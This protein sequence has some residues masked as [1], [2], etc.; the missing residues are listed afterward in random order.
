MAKKQSVID[1]ERGIDTNQVAAVLRTK[2]QNRTKFWSPK[3]G[4]VYR[5]KNADENILLEY[6]VSEDTIKEIEVN[7]D[8]LIPFLFE[9]QNA[10]DWSQAFE[11]RHATLDDPIYTGW[12]EAE[13]FSVT[14]YRLKKSR[15]GNLYSE[16]KDQYYELVAATRPYQWVEYTFA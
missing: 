13:P 11:P 2:A 16:G 14:M 1:A 3:P 12:I 8:F 10:T 6:N 9:N 7:V 15:R 4:C 5:I